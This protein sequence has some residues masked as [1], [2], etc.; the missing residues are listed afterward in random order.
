MSSL[1]FIPSEILMLETGASHAPAFSKKT[2]HLLCP[3]RQGLKAEKA[4]EWE[5]PVVDMTW[6]EG[7]LV[8]TADSLAAKGG[9]NPLAALNEDDGGVVEPELGLAPKSVPQGAVFHPHS[10]SS[11]PSCRNS[12]Y[13]KCLSDRV[14]PTRNFPTC[15]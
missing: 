10:S 14:E 11:D 3:S 4:Q 7:L 8:S 2:T 13:G 12:Q 6:L 5:I 1:C 9:A 15:R